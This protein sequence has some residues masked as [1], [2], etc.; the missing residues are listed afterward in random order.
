M[1]AGVVGG[2]TMGVGI[3]HGLVVSGTETIVVEPVP[4]QRDKARQTIDDVLANGVRRGRLSAED[5]SRAKSLLTF[6]DAVDQLPRQLDIVIESVPEKPALKRAVLKEIERRRPAVIGSNTSSI[7]IGSLGE[8]LERPGSF[9]GTHFFNPVWSMKLVELVVGT[10]TARATVDRARG[11]MTALGKE[12]I[13]VN[14]VPGFATSRL[15]LLL[16][17]EAIRMVE[18]GVA[19]AADIDKAMVLGYGHPMGPL[20]L[21]DLVGLD[22]RLSVARYLQDQLGDRFRPPELLERMVAEGRL[23]RKAGR[24]FYDWES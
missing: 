11:V 22:V 18:S 13:E 10:T 19:S 23:G 3:A 8:D 5:A 12:V 4:A 20:R 9:L 14:D 1:R 17:L 7:A 6:V 2:G 24:G 16:G 21:T 15:G